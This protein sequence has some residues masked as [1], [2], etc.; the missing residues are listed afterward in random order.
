M[1][2]DVPDWGSIA[3][4]QSQTGAVT[5][6]GGMVTVPLGGA[7]TVAVEIIL[8]GGAG[9]VQVLGTADGLNFV[10]VDV[11]SAYPPIRQTRGG[12]T[13]SGFFLI[14]TQGLLRLGF[15]ATGTLAYSFTA[16][17]LSASLPYWDMGQEPMASSLPVV[18]ASDQSPISVRGFNGPASSSVAGVVNAASVAAAWTNLT[19]FVLGAATRY[20]Y[21]LLFGFLTGAGAG[22][23]G[24]RLQGAT[25]G[26]NYDLVQRSLPA[27]GVAGNE[28]VYVP[29]RDLILAG[30]ANGETVNFQYFTTAANGTIWAGLELGS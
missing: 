14:P 28:V 29:P 1:A 21:G 6:A 2:V 30:F 5:V 17:L 15:Q 18:I 25:S 7:P 9:T 13:T 12:F 10:N 20:L 3:T 27:A 4:L 16:F 22:F 8:T 26:V 11:F 19:T 23:A 24:L